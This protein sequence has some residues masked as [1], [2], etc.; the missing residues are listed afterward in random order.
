[1][2]LFGL[3]FPET[4]APTMS[5][6]EIVVHAALI[7]LGL[8]VLLRV[9]PKRQAGKTAVSDLLFVVIIGEIAGDAVSREAK[10]L[11]DFML[12]LLTVMLLSYAVDWL[13]FRSRWLARLLQDKPTCLVRDGRILRANLRREMMSVEDLVTQL[14]LH[15]IED[16]ATVREAYLE[17][18][19]EIS[20]VRKESGDAPGRPATSPKDEHW[21]ETY[22]DD[23]EAARHRR[24]RRAEAL[25]AQ[26]GAAG[27]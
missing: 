12:V 22:T 2:N 9:I 27:N 10:S 19:G 3:N 6:A 16:P 18:D 15:D 25:L 5:A 1:M 13:A 8:C 24:R 7:Y 14:R 26:A 4:F 17:A 11:T 21:R 20:V 23:E